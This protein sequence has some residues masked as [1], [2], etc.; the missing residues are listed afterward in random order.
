MT[1]LDRLE[2]ALR[3][4]KNA[5]MSGA[6][7]SVFAPWMILVEAMAEVVLEQER[8]RQARRPLADDEDE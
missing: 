6:G 2:D 4:C 7:A 3:S 1:T 5:R 8:E